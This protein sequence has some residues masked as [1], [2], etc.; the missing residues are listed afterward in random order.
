MG[1]AQLVKP[2]TSEAWERVVFLS[3]VHVPYQDKP[4]V[5][6]AL[7]LVRQWQPH[8]VV[9]NG[10][11]ADLFILSRFNQSQERMDSL[12]DDI[13]EAN[14]FRRSVREAAPQAVIDE[15]L[16]NHDDRTLTYVKQNARALYS[17]RA[18]QPENLFAYKELG[19]THHP[20]CGFLLRPGFLVKHGTIVR[21]EAGA[22][23]KGELLAAGI[24]GISGHTH[25]LGSYSRAGYVERSWYEQGCLCR[26]D[27]DYVKGGVPNWQQ[28]IAIGEFSTRS[29][30]F[31]VQLV[32]GVDGELRVLGAAA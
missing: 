10:D 2:A 12:Q 28:G 30:A 24:S 23:A 32:P 7:R 19:I 16:G 15:T 3:D 4:L 6:S 21:G 11:V 26:V 18:L 1:R 22:S 9:I 14:D 17:L 8:R 5:E 13:D 29:D 31:Q 25:R 20:G 27:P